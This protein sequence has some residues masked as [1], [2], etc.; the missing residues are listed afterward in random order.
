MEIDTKSSKRSIKWLV[1]N[2][3]CVMRYL[4]TLM[5]ACA[6]SVCRANDK[7][8]YGIQN[9]TLMGF[10]TTSRFQQMQKIQ[11]LQLVWSACNRKLD[12]AWLKQLQPAHMNRICVSLWNN[13]WLIVSKF[14]LL[15]FAAALS[16]IYWWM[17]EASE[18]H[19]VSV[20]ACNF[21]FDCCCSFRRLTFNAWHWLW[22]WRCNAM[23]SKF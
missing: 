18:W 20:F 2:K 13:W 21:D 3:H 16:T 4:H 5:H 1:I 12:E 8:W 10:Q 22:C 15:V 19:G 11:W 23:I 17:D 14:L 6:Q 7:N 9:D